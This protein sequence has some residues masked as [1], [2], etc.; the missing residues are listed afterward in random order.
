MIR[1]ILLGYLRHALTMGAGYLLS[2]GL[3]DQSGIQILA[4]AVLA[5]AGVAWST[6]QKVAADYEQQLARKVMQAGK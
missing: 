4:S 1:Q 5:I 3:V 6:M 2:H